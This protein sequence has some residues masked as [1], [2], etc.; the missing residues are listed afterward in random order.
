MRLTWFMPSMNGHI[1]CDEGESSASGDET[2][3]YLHHSQV[4]I[5]LN[6][7][8]QVDKSQGYHPVLDGR[9]IGVEWEDL[10]LDRVEPVDGNRCF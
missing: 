8:G 10:E 9:R 2:E 5:G 4:P 1:W 3:T 7:I 6:P